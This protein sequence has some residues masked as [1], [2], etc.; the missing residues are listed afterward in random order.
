MGP[1]SCENPNCENFEIF[2]WE[3]QDKMTFECGP[4]GE[5]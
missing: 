4:H 3:S 2:T 1:Q 5:A